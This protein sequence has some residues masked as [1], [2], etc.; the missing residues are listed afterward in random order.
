MLRLE[1][2][3]KDLASLGTLAVEHDGIPRVGELVNLEGLME[4]PGSHLFFV[5]DVTWTAIG[6]RLRA[7]VMAREFHDGFN[8]RAELV[9]AGWL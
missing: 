6:G 4:L 8:R 9:N 3:D 1:L 7:R 5:M 2:Y